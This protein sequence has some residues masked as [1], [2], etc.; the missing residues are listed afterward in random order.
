MF[1]NDHFAKTGSGQTSEKLRNEAVFAGI[2]GS[3]VREKTIVFAF[4][5]PLSHTMK[6]DRFNKTGS[7]QP[8]PKPNTD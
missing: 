1:K 6:H 2:V 8:Q 4:C 5:A 7:G 3:N